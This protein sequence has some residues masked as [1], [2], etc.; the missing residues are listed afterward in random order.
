[1]L[2][3]CPRSTTCEDINCEPR[4]LIQGT[5]PCDIP[6]VT[7]IKG[8]T[9]HKNVSLLTGQCPKCSTL[10]SADHER[11]LKNTNTT[12]KEYTSVYLNSAL[13]LKI[14]QNLWADHGFSNAV[15][16]AMYSFHAS[17]SAY[18]EFWNNSFGNADRNNRYQ[19]THR[20]VWQSFVQ[21]SV[22]TIATSIDPNNNLELDDKL[23]ISEVP[24]QAFHYLGQG[25]RIHLASG[26]TCTECTHKYKKTADVMP[27]NDESQNTAFN[28]QEMDSNTT[29][30]TMV[31]VDR[32]V[33]GP[34]VSIFSK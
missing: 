19:I 5:K 12:N 3:I 10:Y 33:M 20:Q 13:Y 11:V 30:V 32:I 23:N 29:A 7:L 6:K 27:Q 17:S 15:L 34:T 2:V 25:G 1:V 4:S 22:Q 21:E 31:V 8:T 16:N 18:V 26:H 24:G 9:I 28:S 14:G